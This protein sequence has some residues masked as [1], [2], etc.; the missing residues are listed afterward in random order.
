MSVT[1][2]KS[3]GQKAVAL[4]NWVAHG[5]Y[6]LSLPI[7]YILYLFSGM[8]FDA[9]GSDSLWTLWALYYAILAYPYLVVGAIALAWV[10]YLKRWHRSAYVVNALPIV[11]LLIGFAL[12]FAP[13]E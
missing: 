10:A 4:M 9:P 11:L 5:L 12:A 3:S 7:W 1:N 8:L 2:P 13:G 6:L